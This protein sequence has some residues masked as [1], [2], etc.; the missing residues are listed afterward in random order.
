MGGQAGGQ[1]GQAPGRAGLLARLADAAADHVIDGRGVELVAGHQLLQHLGE[2]V[3]RVDFG[4]RAIGFGPGHGAAD[5]ID[6]DRCFHHL[7][8]LVDH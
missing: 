7:M 6:N 3:D 5:G 8:R 2:Q 4:Q 1:P